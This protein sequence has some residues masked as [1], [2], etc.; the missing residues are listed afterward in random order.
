MSSGLCG[1]LLVRF[2][3][4]ANI[5]LLMLYV[6]GWSFTLGEERGTQQKK[7][8]DKHKTVLK[9]PL[10]VIQAKV[11]ENVI[12]WGEQFDGDNSEWLKQLKITIK[13]TSDKTITWASIFLWFPETRQSGPI[14]VAQ[15]FI[16]QLSDMI[17]KNP[18]LDLK[19]GK[20]LEVSVEPNFTSIKKLIE[21]RSRLDQVNE[22]DIELQEVMFDDGTLYSAD[23]IWKLNPETNS[24]RKW[25][26]VRDLGKP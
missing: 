6:T 26:K 22:V 8:V 18:P 10:E 24:P 12:E 14:M 13:N 11:G 23:A 5:L 17:T 3:G 7:R 25:I 1:R 16:G 15:L 21:S 4:A 9:L 2:L 20:E 19:P